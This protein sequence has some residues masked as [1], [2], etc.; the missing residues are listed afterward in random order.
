MATEKEVIALVEQKMEQAKAEMIKE[1]TDFL[2]WHMKTYGL[3]TNFVTT[4]K[5]WKTQHA[6]TA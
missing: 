4:F 6:K 3:T 2:D 1:F 5:E